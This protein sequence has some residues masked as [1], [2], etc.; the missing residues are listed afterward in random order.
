MTP[1]TLTI[2]LDV[3][4]IEDE[5]VA[6]PLLRFLEELPTFEPQSYDLNR[7]GL[8]RAWD[9]D[10]AVVDLLTQRTQLFEVRGDAGDA[11]IATGKHGEPPTLMVHGASARAWEPRMLDALPH[12]FSVTA[13]G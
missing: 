13:P 3:T 7:K 9:L 10:R 8:W 6:R 5:R 12:V 1:D 11:V 2:I 4:A